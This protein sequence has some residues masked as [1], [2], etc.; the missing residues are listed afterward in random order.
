MATDLIQCP[1]CGAAPSGGPDATGGYVCKYCGARF[2]TTASAAA[3]K[4][5]PPVAAAAH[6]PS[7][8]SPARAVKRAA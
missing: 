6:R 2:Q 7:P 5:A 8:A 1:R 3:P 4:A